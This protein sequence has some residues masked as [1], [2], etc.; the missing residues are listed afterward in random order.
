MD[1]TTM[2]R[3]ENIAH[4]AAR[5]RAFMSSGCWY[6]TDALDDAEPRWQECLR[7]LG[8]EYRIDGKRV[9]GTRSYRIRERGSE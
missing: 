2:S 9:D 8:V 5:L 4:V 7:W 6:S 1:G 3:P